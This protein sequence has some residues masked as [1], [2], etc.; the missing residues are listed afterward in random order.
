MIE[1]VET[2][3]TMTSAVQRARELNKTAAGCVYMAAP[4]DGGRYAVQRI[5]MEPAKPIAPATAV[6][7]HP[8]VGILVFEGNA[9]TVDAAVRAAADDIGRDFDLNAIG[10]LKSRT[11]ICWFDA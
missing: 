4:T 6:L 11:T 2:K 9:A 8:M 10:T 3:A 7:V 1:N 5:T